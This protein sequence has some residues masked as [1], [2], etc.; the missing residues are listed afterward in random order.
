MLHSQDNIHS[1]PASPVSLVASD[2]TALLP[3]NEEDFANGMEPQSRAALEDTPPAVENPRLITDQGRSL[4]ATLIQ[5][6]YLWG[7]ISRRAMSRDKST[8]PWEL[9]S[10]YGKMEIKLREWEGGLPHGCQ[11]SNVLLK[12]Y[13]A[14]GE[15]LVCQH[16]PMTVYLGID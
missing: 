11:W 1:G 16:H 12:G 6:H 14:G 2:I 9:N 5:S 7:T 10:E 15:D 8:R 3:C 13:K 4:F